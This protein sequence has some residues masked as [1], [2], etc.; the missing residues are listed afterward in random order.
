MTNLLLI[1]ALVVALELV[2]S[3]VMLIVLFLTLSPRGLDNRLQADGAARGDGFS[4][5]DR[6][7]GDMDQAMRLAFRALSRGSG[8]IA[9]IVHTRA[10]LARQLKAE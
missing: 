10:L 1:Y 9:L 5:S 2:L 8:D 4:S 6:F 3:L 7:P